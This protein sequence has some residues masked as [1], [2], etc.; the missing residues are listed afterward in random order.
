ME[1]NRKKGGD[2][3]HPIWKFRKILGFLLLGVAALIVIITL[4][5]RSGAAEAVNQ[6]E[7]GQ[8]DY[9][10]WVDFDITSDAMSR[11]LKLDV[12]S[13]QSEH[14]INWIEVLAY[15]GTRYGGDWSRY[16]AKDMD[17][18]AEK[19]SAGQ[20]MQELSD[21]MKYYNY[22]Y[23]AYEAVLGGFVGEYSVETP[24]E[25]SGEQKVWQVKYGLKAFSPIAKNYPFNDYDDFGASRTYGF[26]RNHLGHDLMA[27]TGTPVIAVESGVVEV[28]GWNQYGGWRVGIRSFDG[29][30]YYY[31]AHLRQNRPYHCDLEEG[32]AVKAGDVIGYV[33]R[34]GYSI[35]ENVNNINQSHLHFGM[36]LIFDE[37]QKEGNNEIWIDLYE[38]TK[39]LQKN[40]SEVYKVEEQ[41]EYYRVHDFNEPSLDQWKEEGKV[42]WGEI[43]HDSE[44]ES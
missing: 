11:A 36:Q 8:K 37:S 33:G 17:A 13:Q 2:R 4:V 9:I 43:A 16:S 18:L 26:A 14:P 25:G 30:R 21:G 44:E 15:L 27:A 34:T 22:Y 38:I 32:K 39:L 7:A 1:Y 28:I 41:K 20:T 3:L 23:E 5:T 6:G 42:P 10:K 40:K 35:N 12:E 19:L 29:K 24:V 31:Y